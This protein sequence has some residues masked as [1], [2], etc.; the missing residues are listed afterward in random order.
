MI[1]I[2]YTENYA[3]MIKRCLLY[4]IYCCDL[5]SLCT[6]SNSKRLLL[7]DPD[8]INNRLIR[9]EGIVSMLNT[10][11][12][13]VTTENHRQEQEIQRQSQEIQQQRLTIQKQDKTVEQLSSNIQRTY[14]FTI[15]PKIITL[16][17]W[18]GYKCDFVA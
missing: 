5:I 15:S 3:D 13:L 4:V 11:L 18:R 14:N 9:L 12:Q 2:Q 7:N 16:T 8:V 10:S 6:S 17:T 1:R